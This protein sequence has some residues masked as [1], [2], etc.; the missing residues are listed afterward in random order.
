MGF[1]HAD[2]REPYK[3][4]R[5]SQPAPPSGARRANFPEGGEKVAFEVYLYNVPKVSEDGKK[6]L[7]I[8]PHQTKDFDD[9]E[10]ASE[11]AAEQKDKF[12]RVV[13]MRH[14]EEEQKLVKRYT[15]GKHEDAEEIV[16]H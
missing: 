14:D 5:S 1:A 4:H 3:L 2:L 11:F 10:K 8:A 9:L 12:D 13:L 6:A 7:P 15:E 16:R